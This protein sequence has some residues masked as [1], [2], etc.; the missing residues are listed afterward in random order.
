MK[1]A[2]FIIVLAAIIILVTCAAIFMGCKN[3][4]DNYTVAFDIGEY[5][6]EAPGSITVAAG[7]KIASPELS[8]SI[9]P[10]AGRA[11]VWFTDSAKTAVYDFDTP[12][13]GNMTLYLGEDGL[14]YSI[15][16]V[17]LIEGW[18]DVDAL[19]TSYKAGVG[20]AIQ[21][22]VPAGY[23]QGHWYQGARLV[24]YCGV[25]VNE[26]SD[27]VLT[28]KI[29]AI[30]YSIHYTN[31]TEVNG[32][33]YSAYIVNPNPLT[34][35]V[36]DGVVTLEPPVVLEGCPLVFSRWVLVKGND[37]TERNALLDPLS[38]ITPELVVIRSVFIRAVWE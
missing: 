33:D 26:T 35:K 29:E 12:V 5:E 37:Y 32:V 6:T 18:F 20:V 23:Y 38:E 9:T 15:S 13:S 25:S 14:V 1:R 19:P 2:A 30:N 24:G 8:G 28:Y 22:P 21:S 17:D 3:K 27:L 7:S 31:I 11:F 10:Q 16:Y 36:T 4:P 34:Y